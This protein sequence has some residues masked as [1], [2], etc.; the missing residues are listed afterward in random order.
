MVDFTAEVMIIGGG[1]AGVTAAYELSKTHDVILLEQ[2]A[3]LAFHTTSRSAALYIE[4]EGGPVMHRLSTASRSFLEDP[5]DDLDAPLLSPRGCLNIGTPEIAD[6][7]RSDA[8]A[9]AEVTPS[10][11]F[12]EQAEALELCPVLRPER[13][14]CGMFE[15]TAM[16]VDVMALHQLFLRG[17]RQRSA[18]VQRSARVTALARNG[19]AWQAATEAGTVEAGV[20]VNAAGAWGDVVGELAGAAPL[21]LTPCRRTAFT[22]TIDQNPEAWPFIYNPRVAATCYFQPEAGN[23]V[24]GSLA[25]ATPTEP[26]DARP[27][28]ID[29]A[30]AINNINELTTLDIR[31]VNT[32]WAGL[33]TFAPDRHPVFGWDD[34]VD[35]FCWAVGQGGCGIVTSRAAGEVV[36]AVVRGDELPPSIADLGLTLADMAPRRATPSRFGIAP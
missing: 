13:V 28:E 4:N 15:P 31:S 27:E 29:V 7:L 12:V 11:R 8:A 33:R 9:A 1:I 10:I 20:V 32:T 21:G 30:L 16:T 23:Q 5:P 6:K 36:G 24:M 14:S 25:D 17:A 2:E 35:G 19:N 3:E 26:S 22:T 18:Q 34:S